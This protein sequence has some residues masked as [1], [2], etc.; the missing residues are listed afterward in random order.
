MPWPHRSPSQWFSDH[1]RYR[2][3]TDGTVIPSGSDGIPQH[4]SRR[5]APADNPL[6]SLTCA[7]P[8]DTHPSTLE[9]ESTRNVEV[10]DQTTQEALKQQAARKQESPETHDESSIWRKSVNRFATEHPER[11]KLIERIIQTHG[12]ES[13]LK[14]DTWTTSP[15]QESRNKWLRRC[16]PYLPSLR[17]LKGTAAAFANLD[18]HKVA[19]LIVSGVFFVIELCLDSFD[20]SVRDSA[21]SGMLNTMELISKWHDSEVDLQSLKN[22]FPESDENYK[23][24]LA[25]EEDLEELYKGC[26]MLIHS[27]YESGQMRRGRAAAALPGITGEWKL[28]QDRLNEKDK[29]CSHRKRTVEWEVKRRK[30]NIEILDFIRIRGEDPEP[31]HQSI[32][33]RT[34]VNVSTTAGGWFCETADFTSWAGGLSNFET[35]ERLFWLKGPMGTGKTTLM[36]RVMSRFGERPISGVRFVPYYCYASSASKELKAPNYETIVRALCR[37]LAWNGD[38][39]VAEH[40]RKVYDMNK[41]DTEESLTVKKT[42]EPLLEKLV[43]SSKSTVVFVIDALDECIKAGQCKDFLIFL[44]RLSKKPKGPYCLISS[45]PHVPVG[46][47]FEDSFIQFNTIHSDADSDMKKFIADQI[48]YRNNTTWKTSIFYQDNNYRQRLEDALYRTAYGMFRWLNS[49]NKLDTSDDDESAD[50]WKNKLGEAYS[51][52][53]TINGD[54]QYQDFQLSAFRIV[55]GA[56]ESLT[57]QQLLE[58]VCVDLIPP[59]DGHSLCLEQLEGLYCNFLKVDEDGHLDFEHHSAKIF[60]SGMT[61]KDSRDLMF[62][63]EECQ[64][65]LTDIVVKAMGQPSHLI[66]RKYG[67]KLAAWSELTARSDPTADSKPT[68]TS[69][70]VSQWTEQLEPPMWPTIRYAVKKAHFAK[71][72]F[73][74]WILHCK[75][76][77][78]ESQFVRRM[79][80][81]FNNK[82]SGLEYLVLL[83][84]CME[85][86]D[87]LITPSYE[88]PGLRAS[89]ALVRSDQDLSVNLFLF[90]VVLNFSP[91]TRDPGQELVLQK[92][93]RN[94]II[95]PNV[96]KQVSLHIACTYGN[97]TMVT[98]LLEF[99]RAEQGSCMTLLRAKDN[100]DRIP[101]HYAYADDIVKTLMEYEMPPQCADEGTFIRQFDSEDL[102]GITPVFQLV[103]VCTDDYLVQLFNEYLL[104]PETP[105]NA[106]LW[107]AVDYSKEKTVKF[108]LNKGADIN[109]YGKSPVDYSGDRGPAL[110]IA[111]VSNNVPMLELLLDEGALIDGRDKKDACALDQAILRK[112]IEAVKYLVNR[113]AKLDFCGSIFNTPL[114][115][116]VESGIVELAR[117][118]RKCGRTSDIN[119]EGASGTPLTVAILQDSCPIEMIQFLLGEGADPN[120]QG[121]EYDNPLGAAACRDD[122][123]IAELL[124]EKGA[125]INRAGKNHGTALAVAALFNSK[126][127]VKFLLEKQLDVNIKGGRYGT[128]LEAAAYAG[129][130]KIAKLL[131]DKGADPNAQGGEYDSP[132]GAAAYKG[133]I[134]MVKLLLDEQADTNTMGNNFGTAL[135]AAAVTGMVEIAEMLIAAG[136]DVNAQGG[137]HG[138][139]LGAAA[140]HGRMAMANVLL[141]HQADINAKGGIYGSPLGA[142][143]HCIFPQ[144]T[145]ATAVLLVSRGADISL[146]NEEDRAVPL[147]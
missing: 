58:A 21:I 49:L 26:L 83:T 88:A 133:N 52:L 120:V 87:D 109:G 137:G 147:L 14:F 73:R 50:S 31:K 122:V 10:V 98:N 96:H 125:I 127:M 4:S 81:L 90:L 63:Q 27:I 136:A 145:Q 37:R 56:L 69:F 79:I 142:A 116:A 86:K 5:P 128:A 29:D 1:R 118:I 6:E 74:N 45:L 8:T 144:Y 17:V 28:S 80:N 33:E 53:W 94:D 132:L 32:M 92:G 114:H 20:P 143:V 99:Q 68:V 115:L 9:T 42:W 82:Q 124:L 41:M 54:E 36:C 40:A 46:S 34:G 7:A 39:T 59:N 60:I 76:R 140:Y 102:F 43:E 71:Y 72:I 18:P 113:G 141:N 48:D 84:G 89:N 61:K 131:L 2:N 55:T 106:I 64:H 100:F 11:Y 77:R 47:Y 126:K 44:E 16:K 103:A 12:Y 70:P 129:N 23:T 117:I 107:Q 13:V 105:L 101:M 130:I 119:A 19:P 67:I 57:P 38:G 75:N 146:L 15:S 35:K 108:L 3:R 24:V 110:T 93:V 85:Y 62:P 51:R 121:G 112:N 138:T 97:T 95:L 78:E 30:E 66:W 111:A 91:F 139:A 123:E 65:V 22:K 135:I 25:I 104:V 134:E